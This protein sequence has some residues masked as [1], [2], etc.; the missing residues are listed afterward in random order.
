MLLWKLPD[1][2]VAGKVNRTKL[3]GAAEACATAVSWPIQQYLPDV[4]IPAI[5][6]VGQDCYLQAT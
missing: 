2:A 5:L 6:V 3:S 1:A 4:S